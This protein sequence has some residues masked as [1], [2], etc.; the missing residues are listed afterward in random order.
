[1]FQKEPLNALP[2]CLWLVALQ[3]RTHNCSTSSTSLGWKSD[4]FIAKDAHTPLGNFTLIS[5]VLG[6]WLSNK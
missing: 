2:L 1:M 5:G 6:R 4:S 3:A